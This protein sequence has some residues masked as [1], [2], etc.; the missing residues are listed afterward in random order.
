MLAIYCPF[1]TAAVHIAW[2]G[3]K[4]RMEKFAKWWR[5]T[6]ELYWFNLLLRKMSPHDQ[7]TGGYW[8]F[9]NVQVHR[10]DMIFI[11]HTSHHVEVPYKTTITKRSQSMSEFYSSNVALFGVAC[12]YSSGGTRRGAPDK[13]VTY[14]WIHVTCT[15]MDWNSTYEDFYGEEKSDPDFAIN[16][17]RQLMDENKNNVSRSIELFVDITG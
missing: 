15:W 5:H 9:R 13:H 16:C 6:L 17:S 12:D 11:I 7:E 14:T 2:W 3:L 1:L 8:I 10:S 4:V